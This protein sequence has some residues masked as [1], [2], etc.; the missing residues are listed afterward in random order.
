[1]KIG[2]K[3]QG[4]PDANVDTKITMDKEGYIVFPVFLLYGEF[5]QSDFIQQ[6]G[7]DITLRK[8]LTPV[9]ATQLPWDAE[10][11]YTMQSIEVY[12]EAD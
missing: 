4:M 8:A 5:M 10:G 11:D 3:L 7:E 2:K 1:M 6:W 12:F 9:F